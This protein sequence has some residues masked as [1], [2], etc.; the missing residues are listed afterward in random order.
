MNFFKD[1]LILEGAYLI[2]SLFVL[3]I[4]VFVT[5]R[6]F[7]P[8]KAFKIGMISVSSIAIFLVFLHYF[9]TKSRMK[10]VKNAFIQGKTILCEN[11]IY[12]KAAQFIS[13]NKKNDWSIENDSFISPNYTRRF[14]LSRCIVK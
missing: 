8:R 9:V 3:L 5:T 7:M 1:F 14:H 10:E 6:S 4:T 2:I 13:I 12:T 11:R